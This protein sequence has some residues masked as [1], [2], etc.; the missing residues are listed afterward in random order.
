MKRLKTI[1]S[2]TTCTVVTFSLGG[3]E[4]GPTH[5]AVAWELAPTIET[6]ARPA[7]TREKLGADPEAALIAA[8]PHLLK[9]NGAA[10][11]VQGF[12]FMD[13]RDCGADDYADDCVSYRVDGVWNGRDVGVEANYYEERDY[14][15]V[16]GG[17]PLSIGARPISSPSG[18][19]FFAGHHSDHRWSPIQGASVWEWNPHPRRLRVVD[20][21]LVM[22]D[23]FVA[24]HGDGCVEFYGARGY[25]EELQP[26]RQFWLAEVEGDWRLL[27]ERPPNCR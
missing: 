5:A 16:T 9:R 27:E 11:A 12:V 18:N 3:C 8:H 20:T 23:R 15:L 25:M 4:T 2:G 7:P 14:F 21:D 22:F 6:V 10:L 17:D 13:A 24:W 19:R 1:L 26:V